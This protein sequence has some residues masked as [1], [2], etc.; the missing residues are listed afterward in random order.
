[1]QAHDPDERDRVERARRGREHSP[2]SEQRDVAR[3]VAAAAQ[4]PDAA[5][6]LRVEDGASDAPESGQEQCDAVIGREGEQGC[7]EA[8]EHR[9]GDNIPGTLGSIRPV[10]EERLSE[11]GDQAGERVQRSGFGERKPEPPD[12]FG[13]ER[14]QKG[15]MDIVQKMQHAEQ[16]DLL[17]RAGVSDIH[18]D[19]S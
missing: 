7:A 17:R 5:A 3:Q 11:H 2:E 1:M 19:H 16:R 13:N 18:G 8:G 12:Q 10:A 14:R 6:A 15:N 9:T 4:M